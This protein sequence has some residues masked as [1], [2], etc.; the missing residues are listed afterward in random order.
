MKRRFLPVTIAF[1]LMLSLTATAFGAGESSTATTFNGTIE[2]SNVTKTGDIYADE[3]FDMAEIDKVLEASNKPIPVEGEYEL[4]Y[5]DAPVTVTLKNTDQYDYGINV[6]HYYYLDEASKPQVDI[7]KY[8]T[9][10]YD[11]ENFS[12][13][14]IASKAF[15][16]T[17]TFNTPGSYYLYFAN[18]SPISTD[19]DT[20]IY[21]IVGGQEV[22]APVVPAP[23]TATAA[24]TTAPVLV[25]SASTAFEAY[26]ING[27]NYFKLRDLAKVV[28]GTE[29]NFEVTWD[30]TKNAIN[31]ISNSGYTSVGGELGKGD[32]KAK[33]AT[34][35]TSTIY[36]DGTEVS[37]TA[38]HINGNNY[39]K[40]RDVAQAFDIGVT[41]DHETKTVGIDT[42]TSYI[43][44]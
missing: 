40:L 13:E 10:I 5:A 43:P 24:P 14:P 20:G 34:L 11:Y 33:T 23:A 8:D 27:N 35:T 37:L 1:V 21:I 41:W 25:N 32:G 15:E 3:S 28:D 39:F 31:L 26:N 42:A 12:L 16:G 18:N 17:M 30:G 9:F 7:T 22:T 2:I 44:E 4:Y 36:K 29:K 6:Y 38:Y 19:C